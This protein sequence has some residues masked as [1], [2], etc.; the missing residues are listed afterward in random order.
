MTA[1]PEQKYPLTPEVSYLH[2]TRIGVM[3]EFE[4]DEIAAKD[5]KI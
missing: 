2:G 5:V 3:V 1:K 4:G